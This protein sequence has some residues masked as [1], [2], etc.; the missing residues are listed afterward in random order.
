MNALSKIREAG[1]CI[2][3]RDGEKLAVNPVEKL[4]ESQRDFLKAN[5]SKIIDELIQEQLLIPKHKTGLKPEH[6]QKLLDYMAF[7]D[8]TD[9]DMIDEYLSECEN[10]PLILQHQLEYIAEQMKPKLD[11]DKLVRCGDCLYFQSFYAHGG[12]GGV[13]EAKVMPLGACHYAESWR[14][15]DEWRAKSE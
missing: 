11:M 5:K 15:C 2:E 12:A 7:I 8:E 3:I 9:N 1:F 14:G 4:T 13:C 10:N 6:R